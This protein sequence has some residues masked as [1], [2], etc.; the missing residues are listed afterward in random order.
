[1]KR[2]AVDTVSKKSLNA[3]IEA[4]RTKANKGRY[5]VELFM[6]EAEISN[7][8]GDKKTRV[9]LKRRMRLPAPPF[10][11]LKFLIDGD[12]YWTREILWDAAAQ[13][14]RVGI[15]DPNARPLDA[16]WC[17]RAVRETLRNLIKLG[18]T[19]GAPYES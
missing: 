4:S 12:E 11:D 5:E 18:W 19:V 6:C 2:K 8:K 7:P 14:Y 10:G 15:Y 16:L 3:W 17:D 13:V 1:V 9:S